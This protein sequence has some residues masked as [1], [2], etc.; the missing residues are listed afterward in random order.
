MTPRQQKGLTPLGR[1]L[2]TARRFLALKVLH[3]DDPPHAIALGVAIGV[4][5]AFLP[6]VGFQTVIAIAAAALLRANKVVCVPVVWITNPVTFGPIY[7]GCIALGQLVLPGNGT[8][9]EDVRRLLEFG[10]GRSVLTLAYWGDLLSFL[11]ELAAELWVG[12]FIVSVVF[13][14]PSY[15]VA[16]TAVTNYRNR[17]RQKLLKRSLFRANRSGKKKSEQ[18]E[19]A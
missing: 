3:T 8:P 12:C 7:A 2:F 4:F 9:R 19:P 11:G 16:R 10:Q 17:R 5:V 14:I 13:A 6:L 15:F 18:H 1:Y